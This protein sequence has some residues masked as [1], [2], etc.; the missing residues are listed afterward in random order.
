MMNFTIK[1]LLIILL[2]IP[3]SY[4]RPDQFFSEN[5]FSCNKY[6]KKKWRRK[7]QPTPVFLPGKI[8]GQRSLAG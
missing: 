8:H 3:E 4:G 6:R 2:K 1:I 7:W 5:Y